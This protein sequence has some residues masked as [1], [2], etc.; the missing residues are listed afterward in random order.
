M[1]ISCRCCVI[2]DDLLSLVFA[3]KSR[4]GLILITSRTV[5]E[6]K[7]I[8]T[9]SKSIPNLHATSVEGGPAIRAW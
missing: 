1:H 9:C 2:L 8:L 5:T 7:A 3:V 6:E 4:I